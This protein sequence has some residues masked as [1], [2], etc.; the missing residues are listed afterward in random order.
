MPRYKLRVPQL[1]DPLHWDDGTES[2]V[3]DT[4][5]QAREEWEHQYGEPAPQFL[6]SEI[7]RCQIVYK[8]DLENGDYHE[9]AEPGDTSY[10]MARDHGGELLPNEFRCW[11]A[12]PPR[13]HW[14]M[15]RLPFPEIDPQEIPPAAN[16][17]HRRHGWGQTV[18]HAFRACGHWYLTCHF[19]VK[20]IN[21]KVGVVGV[22][23]GNG[24]SPPPTRYRLEVAG[25]H[26]A[27]GTEWALHTLREARVARLNAEWDAE[28]DRLQ[29]VAA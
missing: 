14:E 24:W 8:R 21:F 28:Q 19:G 16:V 5:A 6:H 4:L 10:W 26:V 7:G 11:I 2:V 23:Y 9:D 20:P 17:Y 27:D 25:E 22:Y 15:H 1:G 3:A 12:G 13:W 18:T 29:T